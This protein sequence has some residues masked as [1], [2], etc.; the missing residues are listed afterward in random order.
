ML[1]RT[2]NIASRFVVFSTPLTSFPLHTNILL[3]THFG[4]RY[5]REKYP[6]S[7]RESNLVLSALS[8]FVTFAVI[9]RMVLSATT[10]RRIREWGIDVSIFNH[11]T[12]FGGLLLA[13]ALRL[14][15]NKIPVPRWIGSWKDGDATKTDISASVLKF[16][17]SQASSVIYRIIIISNL[18]QDRSKASSK[19]IPPLNAI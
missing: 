19:T 11:G 5:L 9:P 14:T 7:C 8:P 13:L 12:V 6:C 17:F 10:R 3:S 16:L 4:R 1:R 15:R 18:L 2:E